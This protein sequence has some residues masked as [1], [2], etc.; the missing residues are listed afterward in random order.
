MDESPFKRAPDLKQNGGLSATGK[1]KFAFSAKLKEILIRFIPFIGDIHP[2]YL[3]P[4]SFVILITMTAIFCSIFITGYYEALDKQFLSPISGSKPSKYCQTISAVNTGDYLATESGLW[5]GNAAFQYA[6]AA[7]TA[8]VTSWEGSYEQYVV[9]MNEIYSS[10][11]HFG[12]LATRQDLAQNLV[13]W[14][15]LVFVVPYSNAQRFFLNGTPLTVLNRQNTGGTVS[16]VFGDCNASSTASFDQ[17]NGLLILIYVYEEFVNNSLCNG[18][19]NP[20]Q[21]G[22]TPGINSKYFTIRFDVRTLVTTLAI[23]INVTQL[24][25]MV[26]IPGFNTN[27]TFE[28]V[29]YNTSSYYDPKYPGMAP[30]TCISAP[31]TQCILAVGEVFAL[32]V[33]N[34]AGASGVVPTVCDC[35]VLSAEDLSSRYSPCNLFSFLSGFIFWPDTL[36]GSP[37]PVFEMAIG[38]GYD[39][40]SINAD[41]FN[42]S[43]TASYWGATSPERDDLNTAETRRNAYSFCN[44]SEYGPC[45]MVTFSSFD[46]NANNW[47]VSEFYYQVQNGACRDTFTTSY[48]DW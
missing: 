5:E 12:Q 23:N 29:A 48:A 9:L 39:Y 10:L 32:P 11:T 27:Y 28:G 4:I 14:M 15:S 43:F 36:N 34:H 37:D 2:D 3:F 21:L 42:A 40:A 18:T 25:D 33:F 17:S 24:S 30:L 41:A 35:D 31:A 47:A 38:Y 7:Y 19:V 22:Y 45:S 44:V 16:N 6:E 46:T 8:S 20:T 26:E 1:V 13:Y